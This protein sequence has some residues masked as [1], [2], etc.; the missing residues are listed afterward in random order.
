M[1]MGDRL[2]IAIVGGGIGGLAA[3]AF[4]RRAGLMATVYEQAGALT[5]VGAGI[6]VA[7]NAARLLRRLGVMDR[8]ARDAVPLDWGW[9]FRRWENGQVLSVERLD[10][11]CERLYG[12]R[13]YVIHRADLLD[14]V[15]AAVTQAGGRLGRGWPRGEGAPGRG[16]P[17]FA[18]RG[19]RGRRG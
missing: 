1:R 13:T 2:R 19:P 3:A 9:E 16:A 14:T 18:G 4:L 8:F 6:V 17:R 7:P 5:A 12:E 11:V 15:K 10:G